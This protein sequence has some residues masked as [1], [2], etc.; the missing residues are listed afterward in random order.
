MITF[1]EERAAQWEIRKLALRASQRAQGLPEQEDRR[2]FG[3]VIDINKDPE[4]K[5]LW[6]EFKLKSCEDIGLKE[7]RGYSAEEIAALLCKACG[8]V[9]PYNPD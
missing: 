4:L 2:P 5:R 7:D 6:N 9:K 3:R 8:E 1:A